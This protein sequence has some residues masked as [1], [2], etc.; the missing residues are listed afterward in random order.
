M[1]RRPYSV[2]RKKQTMGVVVKGRSEAASR[3]GCSARLR[4]A[5][6]RKLKEK[7]MGGDAACKECSLSQPARTSLLIF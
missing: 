4:E 3:R 1:P 5:L 2:Q 7:I 6:P